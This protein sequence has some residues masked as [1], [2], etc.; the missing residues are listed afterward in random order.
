MQAFRN[1]WDDERTGCGADYLT[2]Q[3]GDALKDE[4]GMTWN[5]VYWT[6]GF[7]FVFRKIDGY[8][9]PLPDATFKL[10]T[11]VKHEGKLVP[12]KKD[13]KDTP[14]ENREGSVLAEDWKAYEQWNAYQQPDKKT[15]EKGDAKGISETIESVT[16]KAYKEDGKP[17]DSVVTGA[18]LVE[19]D[20]IPPGNYF[21]VETTEPK[22]WER[23]V[24]VYRVY[25]DGTGWVSISAVDTDAD[26]KLL[27]PDATNPTAPADEPTVT[28]AKDDATDKYI[29]P[30]EAPAEGAD[31]IKIFNILNV[32]SLSRK[33]ILKK[34]DIADNMPLPE[35]KFTVYWYDGST[36]M[37]VKTTDD[38]GKPTFETLKD[39]ESGAA[40]AFWIGWLPSGIYYMQETAPEGY[41]QPEKR[42]R[43]RVDADGVTILNEETAPPEPEEG[44]E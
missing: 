9:E 18:G 5:C 33:V 41:K 4:N 37:R 14:A 17:E 11:S 21:M 29:L 1:A 7:D 25:V 36:V 44:G 31:T 30:E 27:W 15:K 40:G 43:L 8:G 28:F 34:V 38:S 22:N 23:M 19:F 10:Y 16:V 26:G 32:S 13:A 24:D 35:A 39:L 20:K 3:D 2:G 12:A 6:G 42:V